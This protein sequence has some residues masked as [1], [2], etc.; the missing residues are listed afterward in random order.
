M[1]DIYADKMFSVLKQS[2]FDIAMGE[3]LLD[4][5]VGTAVMLV[6]KGDAVNPINFIPVPQYL[7][8]FEVA[9]IILLVAIIAAVALTLRRRKDTKTQDIAEQIRTRK[10]DR[11]RMV[12]TMSSG[13]SSD[14]K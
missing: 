3:F 6:Q 5:S 2:N 11:I 9:G 1:L 10:E 14:K 8:S 13:T 12:T 7:F 4:L